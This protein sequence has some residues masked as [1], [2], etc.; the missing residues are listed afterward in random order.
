MKKM[1]TKVQ[2]INVFGNLLMFSCLLFLI[3][4]CNNEVIEL[5]EKNGHASLIQNQKDYKVSEV[6]AIQ[7]LNNFLLSMENNST[8]NISTRSKPVRT[9][10]NIEAIRY[11]KQKVHTYAG[12]S[13]FSFNIDTLMYLINFE[14]NQ[15]YA[16]VSADKRTDQ[17]YAIIDEGALSVD[18]IDK[19]NNPGFHIALQ[20]SIAKI[21]D[22]INFFDE[23][24]DVVKTYSSANSYTQTIRPLLCVKWGQRAPYDTYCNG[25][26][27]GCVITAT[28]QILS[29]YQT[30]T[31]VQ[32]YYSPD[33]SSGASNL[34][35]SKIVSDS[36]GGDKYGRLFLH[37]AY[38]SSNQVAHLMRY[39][40]ISFRASY[41][42][43]GTGA[44]NENAVAWMQTTGKLYSTTNLLYYNSDLIVTS[45]NS[46]KLIY[47]SAFDYDYSVNG[48]GHTWVLDGL[49]RIFENGNETARYVHCNWGWDGWCDGYFLDN[50]YDT[51]YRPYL[52]DE[53]D[54]SSGAQTNTRQYN[55]RYNTVIAVTGK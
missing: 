32:W 44:Y 34:K 13:D 49:H 27:T 8:E 55:F 40:G 15:G 47:I 3:V 21:H 5:S 4:S 20:N 25:F 26:P 43:D 37:E 2:K 22:D 11:D 28:S 52:R 33:G 46:G 14:N 6:E 31:S 41:S 18:T 30:L 29:Y 50:I 9:V 17:V 19:V 12:G 23:E 36:E 48:V 51:R 39:L 1:N 53:K 7:N 16:L 45:L 35:W 24:K 38:S 42:S 54:I 10:K